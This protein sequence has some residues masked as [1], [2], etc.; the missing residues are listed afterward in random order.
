MLL[1]GQI[2]A[3]LKSQAVTVAVMKE[4]PAMTQIIDTENAKGP[5]RFPD[6]PQIA[7]WARTKGVPSTGT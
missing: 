1:G 2:A 3:C 6:R 4:R 7:L 5:E